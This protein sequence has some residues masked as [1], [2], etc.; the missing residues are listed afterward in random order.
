MKS[1]HIPKNLLQ[2]VLAALATMLVAMPAAHADDLEVFINPGLQNITPNLVFVLDLSGS[3][4]QAPDGSSPTSINP[5][6]LE[7]LKQAVTDILADPNL[8]DINVGFTYF[9]DYEGSGIKFPASKFDSDASTID[10]GI[11]VGMQVADV[12]QSMVAAANASQETPTVDALYEV[13]RYLRGE[14]PLFGVKDTFGTWNTSSNEYTGGSGGMPDGW[15]AANPVSYTGGKAYVSLS[16]PLGTN[17][18]CNDWSV[19]GGWNGC[20][21]QQAAGAPMACVPKNWSGRTCTSSTCDS[22]CGQIC[23][24]GWVYGSTPP[25]SCIVNS[26]GSIWV[27]NTSGGVPT[28]CCT[29]SDA[30][31]SECTATASYPRS[32]S[33]STSCNVANNHPGGNYNQCTYR[34]ADVRKYTSPITQQCQ[35]TGVVLLTDGDPSANTVDR[36]DNNSSGNA[37]WPYRVRDLIASADPAKTRNDIACD[38]YSTA[39]GGSPGGQTFANCGKEL[40]E[41][42]HKEDQISTLEGTTVDTYAIG[43][44]LVGPVA[45]GTWGYLTDVADAGGGEAFQAADL[46]TLVDA[47]RSIISDVTSA[48]QRFS[49][50][51]TSFDSTTLQSGNKAYLTLFQPKDERAWDGNVKGYFVEQGIIK[52]VTGA[53][54]TEVDAVTGKVVF[55]ANARS[56]WS[57]SPDGNTPLN[58]GV[59]DNLSP[60]SRNIYVITDASTTNVNLSNGSYDMTTSNPGLTAAAM[61]MA[62]SST[63]TDIAD[64]I[65]WAK[66]RRMGDPLHTKPK[67]I[68]YHG[69]VGEVLF[70]TTNQGYL[71]AISVEHPT[72]VNDSTGGTEMFAF[73]PRKM[74]ANLQT[75]RAGTV[76]G[77]H[78]Y[79]LDGPMTVALKDLN[80]DGEIDHTSGDKAHL[81]FG[82]RRGGTSYYALDVSNPAAPKLAWQIDAGTSGFE[83]LGET[84]SR[85]TVAKVNDGG[86][87]RDVLIF[88]GGYDAAT[89]DVANQSR[90]STGDSMG[91]GIYI[92]DANSGAL[93]NSIGADDA[94][95]VPQEFA[96]DVPDMKYSIP[97]DIRAEDSNGNGVVDRL[98]VGDMGAQLWR[99][100]IA[101]GAT[102]SASTTIKPY[103]LADLSGSGSAGNRRFYY[104]PSV[105]HTA[106]DGVTVTSL[107]IGSGYRAHPL[108][109]T[110]DDKFF[111][112]FDPD[113]AVGA[114]GT[115]PAAMTAASLYDATAN[116]IQTTSG[117][118]QAAAISALAAKKG[119][120][121]SMPSDQQVLARARTFKNTVFFT[122]FESGTVDPCDFTGGSNHFYA[123]K[124]HDATGILETDVDNDGVID[125]IE[126]DRVVNDE[127][128]ILGEPEFLTHAGPGTPTSPAPFCTTVFAGSTPAMQICD[129]PVRVNWQAI[130]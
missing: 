112:V 49:G 113:V 68:R 42:L 17:K 63:A 37:I 74:V 115:T 71:H 81:Y 20:A 105:A 100:D 5:S 8:P 86:T 36:G 38:D 67:T 2:A 55:K 73:M 83:R 23:T 109:S 106:R 62:P 72:G 43:F 101:E 11:P 28:A 99:V 97:S 3:M 90:S 88:G 61:G 12:V 127:A 84:W 96:V 85:M 19:S 124:L 14:T 21:T 82:M 25:S 111:V 123:V 87:P 54:A 4:D 108:N 107:A 98:Y 69:G 47:F 48:N 50:F 35:K 120:F 78:I 116:L 129:S 29:A 16:D 44:G 79:G 94:L 66:S 92:V 6:R 9:R 80:G 40:A 51:A 118:T 110:I 119:W 128:A 102:L 30:G 52:D 58:G 122:S 76:S 125:T 103:K 53:P 121:I 39:F 31:L 26:S 59:L 22:S 18:T 75:Q 45:T 13:A 34:E 77:S 65:A 15:R 64:M 130:Q 10:A 46:S 60:A 27:T 41:F 95:T 33:T 93:L 70:V 91:M 7:I 1:K 24:T 56:F 117:G 104:P 57:S 114:P 126:R 89:Q 32:C